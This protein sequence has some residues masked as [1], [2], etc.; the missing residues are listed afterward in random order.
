[1]AGSQGD[2]TVLGHR[3]RITL[4]RAFKLPARGV[5]LIIL[6]MATII[7]PRLSCGETFTTVDVGKYPRSIAV[8]PV[9]NKVYVVNFGDKTVT[10]IN[11]DT[12]VPIT[13]LVVGTYP[14][15]VTVNP[16][17][18]KIYVL[19]QEQI[20]NGTVTVIDGV[21]DTVSATVPV[22]FLPNAIAVNPVTNKVYVANSI[23][24]TVTVIDGATNIPDPTPVGVG[25]YPIAIAV[26]PVTNKIYVANSISNTVTVI[27]GVTNIPDPTPVGVGV[28]PIAIAVNTVTNKVYVANNG[29]G[30]TVIDVTNNNTTAALAAG[31]YPFAVALNQTTN[32]IYVANQGNGIDSSTVTVVNGA[33]NSTTSVAI[34]T[35]P[36]AVAVNPGTN[37]VYV[38]NRGSDNVTV[39][40][41]ATNT[42]TTLDAAPAD[43]AWDA[44]RAIAV[45]PGT[46]K[47]YVAN[48]LSNDVTVMQNIYSVSIIK[49][50][51]GTGTVTSS[52]ARIDCGAKCSAVFPESPAVVM[53]QTPGPSSGFSGWGGACSGTG[54][55]AFSM[56][57]DK[58]VSANFTLSP[59]VKNKTTGVAYS[60][61]QT[62]YNEA[63]SGDTISAL[64]TLPAAG[65][66]LNTAV[67]LTL[68]GG[69]DSTYSSC[70]GLTPVLGRVNISIAPLRVQGLA[71]RPAL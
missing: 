11:G 52:R 49:S 69:Y 42:P 12:A 62:A 66:I 9:T 45:N 48:E 7:M 28:S 50:G 6:I 2:E 8:N 70:I 43:P 35:N 20:G 5:A 63:K 23:S 31:S 19:N 64:S 38:A 18:N 32:K 13:T 47:V 15:A 37:K 17:T 68:E 59:L 55:C 57:S 22:Q 39:I 61:L 3:E 40:D 41:G 56:L 10:V 4:I 34:G 21:T 26:N 71:I 58:V 30:I 36:Y 1:M 60:S 29:S 44:P 67:N 33:T 16:A 54:D 14:S 46:N 65:L 24:N 51:T 25:M 53:F 27:D